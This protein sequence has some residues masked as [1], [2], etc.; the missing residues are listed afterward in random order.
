LS[1]AAFDFGISS[2][3][4]T[5]YFKG[6][7]VLVFEKKV[8]SHRAVVGQ[9]TYLGMEVE[10]FATCQEFEESACDKSG[11]SF[12][13]AE[14][15]FDGMLASA[16]VKRIR[17]G[18]SDKALPIVLSGSLGAIVRCDLER[19][20]SLS[21]PY[22][23]SFVKKYALEALGKGKEKVSKISSDSVSLGESTPLT[24][25][26][27]EDNLVNQKVATRLFKKMGYTIDV[28]N[29]GLEAI[30]AISEK[31]YDLV[32]MDIQ[33]PEMDGLEASRTIIERWGDDRPRIVA[34]TANAMRED[35]ENCF[36]AGMDDYLTKPFKPEDLRAVI[37]KTYQK[38]VDGNE[39][40][41]VKIV[42]LGF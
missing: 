17:D 13:I 41:P 18:Q 20:Y 4:S 39:R 25:L 42:D 40:K 38:L 32:F 12:A 30:D 11:Y 34:L 14:S 3:L 27:A 31:A 7:K 1:K 36:Q 5:D 29:N 2:G 6:K 10:T 33:M 8:F 21:K 26:L 16:L 37:V 35:R 28:A 23:L 15:G 24:I 22:K 9:L 19:T